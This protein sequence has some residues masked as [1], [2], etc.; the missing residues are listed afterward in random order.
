MRAD[1][2]VEQVENNLKRARMIPYVKHDGTIGEFLSA[3][4]GNITYARRNAFKLSAYKHN[5][6]HE[7][8]DNSIM[9]IT[10]VIPN[11]V[12]Y[13]GC[14]DAWEAISKVLGP[15]IRALRKLGIEKYIATLEAT[16]EGCCHAHLLLRW[17]RALKGKTQNGK[18]YL[19]ED[20]LAKIIREK[21]V[22]E[23][24]KVSELQLNN[25]AVAIRVC[26]DL[27]EANKTFRYVTKFLGMGSLI[28]NAIYRV[29]KGIAVSNDSAKLLSNYWAYKKRI[30]LCRTSRGLGKTGVFYR[31]TRQNC[32]ADQE[33]HD[34]QKHYEVR[35][36][37][38]IDYRQPVPA[39]VIVLVRLKSVSNYE[40]FRNHASAVIGQ[41]FD[42]NVVRNAGLSIFDPVSMVSLSNRVREGFNVE[43]LELR[44]IFTQTVTVPPPSGVPTL[45]VEFFTGFIAKAQVKFR[46]TDSNGIVSEFHERFSYRDVCDIINQKDE[47]VGNHTYS[48]GRIFLTTNLLGD[49]SLITNQP[50]AI[51]GFS[52][53]EGV[54]TA[55]K[56]FGYR[57]LASVRFEVYT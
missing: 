4:R 56:L 16:N 20:D 25:H 7:A 15:Y 32:K 57:Q 49:A 44:T 11:D 19:A 31:L 1:R 28:S 8:I 2:V 53:R 23:W 46:L 10:L 18:Y 54:L 38:L 22:K 30:R 35:D 51:E 6:L 41:F 5:L 36:I 37:G 45:E 14:E 55:G 48:T 27:T 34:T 24:I 33:Q 13:Y 26:P 12:S 42:L 21:L 47:V 40:D 3:K 50:L 39:Q 43:G 52:N 17:N 9:F 29:K